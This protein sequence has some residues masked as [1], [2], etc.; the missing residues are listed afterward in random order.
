VLLKGHKK[1]GGLAKKW[2]RA[3]VGKPEEEWER[4]RRRKRL[5]GRE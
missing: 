2:E 3:E 1:E 4:S 5:P